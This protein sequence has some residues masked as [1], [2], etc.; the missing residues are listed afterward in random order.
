MFRLT[1]A[2]VAA[3]NRDHGSSGARGIKT[4]G[5][6][7]KPPSTGHYALSQLGVPRHRM[8]ERCPGER[9]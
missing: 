8:R 7:Q 6:R 2:V 5:W 4:S 1:A 9:R 3:V